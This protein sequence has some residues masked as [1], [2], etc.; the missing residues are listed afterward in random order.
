MLL[1]CNNLFFW[2]TS[3]VCSTK[4]YK[5]MFYSCVFVSIRGCKEKNH[6]W[7]RIHTNS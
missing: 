4:N 2:N 3:A 1:T 7:T 6:E 5:T